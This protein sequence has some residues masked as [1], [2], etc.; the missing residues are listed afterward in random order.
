MRR[1]VATGCWRAS[2]SIEQRVE[3]VAQPVELL[4]GLR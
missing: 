3:L 4:V 2:R 1:S